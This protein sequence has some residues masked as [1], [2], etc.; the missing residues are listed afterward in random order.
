[1]KYN[2]TQFQ[3]DLAYFD[4]TLTD[5]QIEQFMMYYEMLIEKNKVMNLTSITEFDE[6]MK[7]HFVDSLS[8]VKAVDL[9]KTKSLIDIGTG[10]GFPG[11]P[12]KIAFPNLKITLLDSLQ[13]RVGFLQEVIDQLGLDQITAIHGRAED[14]AKSGELEN[15]LR[16]K[17]DI[18]VSR[19]VANL[20]V[21]S[22]YCIPY[23][24]V[25]GK[26]ISYKSEK[27]EEECKDAE[28]AVSLLGGKIADTVSFELPDSSIYRTF[29]VIDKVEQTPFQY[30]RKAGAALK[31]PL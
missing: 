24:K 4:L 25:G 14:F 12:L 13:K 20:A 28:H 26:F 16:E 23:V 1:M 3:K 21:L 2:L 30:P 7:K 8:L 9:N 17:C 5:R 18:C 19:A 10:A 15:T 31:K 22:E 29:V 6:V 11:I 27:T